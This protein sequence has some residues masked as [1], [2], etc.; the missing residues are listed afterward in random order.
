MH[1]KARPSNKRRARFLS[2]ENGH[3]EA[4]ERVALVPKA[5]YLL[6]SIWDI[7]HSSETAVADLGK[8]FTEANLRYMRLF[9]LAFP[10][11]YTLC[12]QLSWRHYRL[13]MQLEKQ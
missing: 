5:G 9:Y 13:H 1:G 2:Q 11:V 10:K 3:N 7:V 6:S 4:I 8:G 12:E